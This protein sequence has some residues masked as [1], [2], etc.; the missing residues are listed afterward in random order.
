MRD[1]G[2]NLRLRLIASH[3]PKF[4]R[5]PVFAVELE[6]VEG[7]E[8]DLAVM[9]AAVELFK[10]RHASVIAADRFAVDRH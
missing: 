9:S 3:I 8:E 1:R 4:P 5:P 2:S 6:E 10:D 7:I